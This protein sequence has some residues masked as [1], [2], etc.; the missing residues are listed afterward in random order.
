MNLYFIDLRPG[1]IDLPQE[2]IETIKTEIKNSDSKFI[3]FAL[4]EDWNYEDINNGLKKF[5]VDFYQKN[6]VLLVDILVNNHHKINFYN[7]IRYDSQLIKVAIDEE[8]SEYNK[9]I[10]LDTG[11]FLFLMGKPYK[12]HRI[13]LLHKLYENN[14]L[15]ECDYS[16]VLHENYYERTRKV[17]SHLTDEEF[18]NFVSKT[19]KNLDDIEFIIGH[20]N[21]HYNGVPV[22]PNLYKN[23]SFSLL[24]ESM[25]IPVPY[26]FLSEKFW[27]T[28]ASHHMF[29]LVGNELMT[30]NI[31]NMG[32]GTFQHFLDVDKSNNAGV[33]AWLTV[34]NS[35]KNVKHL[36][37]TIGNYREAIAFQIKKNYKTY[38]QRIAVSRS[39]VDKQLEKYLFISDRYD[40][41]VYYTCVR[42]LVIDDNLCDAVQKLF[43]EN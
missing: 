39:V 23:T 2:E 30:D 13:G 9:E 25:C 38:K 14:L 1:V 34:N 35:V 21:Y 19:Q 41:L 4:D 29:I 6:C 42:K 28:I 32:F 10:N 7:I 3:F 31:H 40:M 43:T 24:S 20:D 27:R 18:T 8:F 5:D 22:D 12:I 15:N 16:F 33:D 37:N 26:W 11:R 36:L 17:L